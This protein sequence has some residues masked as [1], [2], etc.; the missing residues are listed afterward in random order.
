MTVMPICLRLARPVLL[1]KHPGGG[2]ATTL[3]PTFPR[4]DRPLQPGAVVTIRTLT[5]HRRGRTLLLR[6]AGRD[7]TRMLTYRRL[8]EVVAQGMTQM[9]TY[10]LR[11][12][13]G[14]RIGARSTKTVRRK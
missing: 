12:L 6:V 14:R 8:A 5:C 4:L 2:D 13:Q 10:L 1:R 3:T 11:G 9:L 7:M